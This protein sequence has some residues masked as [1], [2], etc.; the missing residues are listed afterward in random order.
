MTYDQNGATFTRESFVSAPANALVIR[1]TANK[2]GRINFIATLTRPERFSTTVSDGILTMTGRLPDGKGGD[3]MAYTVRVQIKTKGGR[4]YASGANIY[5]EE[6]DE[7]IVVL[8][9]ST[10]YL[11]VYPLYKGRNFEKECK[12]VL[13]KAFTQSYKSLKK[14]HIQN[15]RSFFDR[16]N[17]QLA[18][19]NVPDTIPTEVRLERVKAGSVDNHLTQLY[20][21]YG[22][23][24]L[25]AS[26]RANT[27]PANLQGIWANKIQTPWNADYHTNINVQMNYWPAEVCNL[28]EIH[29]SLTRFIQSLEEPATRSAK[30]QF[31][32]EGW[33]INPITNVWGFTA[34]GEHPSWGLTPGAT[35]WICRHLW[36]HYEYTLDKKYLRKVYPTLKNAARFYLDWLVLDPETLMLVSG[37]SSSPENTFKATDGSTGTISMGPTHD[38]QVIRELFGHVLEAAHILGV[39]DST[40]AQIRE[41]LPGLLNTQIGADGRILEWAKPYGEPE[42]G[43]RHMS[44]LYGLHPGNGFSHSSGLIAAAQKS[45]EYRLSHG[46]GQTGWSAAW[47]A[48]MRARLKQGDEALAQIQ[49]ILATKSAPNLFNLHPPF[50]IDGNFGATAG[51]AEM[52]LQSHAGTIGLV[53]QGYTGFIELLPALPS[54]WREGSVKGLKARG[55]FEVDMTWKE[56][57]LIEAAV[58]SQT[59]TTCWVLYNTERK[60]VKLT[61]GKRVV[62]AF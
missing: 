21:Q 51:I 23:Y 57:K 40:T 11:P 52:L 25:I 18:D 16:V 26:A 14:A 13:D 17:L 30:V 7:A 62:V 29:L 1:L 61:P 38:Q 19:P 33:C 27:L 3:G 54:A 5:V 37:P 22:R 50:Q 15:H 10:D 12:T 46:G 8:T 47:I 49:D 35:G 53:L 32:A 6:A 39:E 60:R 45:L 9:A 24:L 2:K 31:G 36:E 20:F 48:N 34:P 42:P 28:S 56:G 44:H 4:Q 59:E 58:V 41:A 43:H 55:G